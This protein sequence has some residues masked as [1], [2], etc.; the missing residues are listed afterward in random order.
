MLMHDINLLLP[1]A[2]RTMR[3]ALRDI[4]RQ[5]IPFTIEGL[6][7]QGLPQKFAEMLR[8]SVKQ[9]GGERL[10][11]ARFIADLFAMNHEDY[12]ARES[13]KRWLDSHEGEHREA[14]R[15]LTRSVLKNWYRDEFGPGQPES[16]E[17]SDNEA[18]ASRSKARSVVFRLF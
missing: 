3:S 14:V 4:S 16:I 7:K 10:V 11:V 12:R 17:I 2:I 13:L 9:S 1:S 6:V 5:Q 15:A 18:P 8:A